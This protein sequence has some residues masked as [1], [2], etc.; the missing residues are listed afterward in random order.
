MC[1]P[2]KAQGKKSA[3][4]RM[5]PSL[6]LDIDETGVTAKFQSQTFK[7]ARFRVG[8]KG[9]E[10][11]VGGAELDPLQ[12]RFRQ[13]VAD[14][15]SQL[16]LVDVGKDM[17][18]GRE[19]GNSTLSTGTPER[20]SGPRPEMIP[21]PETPTLSAQLPSPRATL[22]RRQHPESFFDKTSSPTHAP[23]ADR[24]QYDELT[25]GQLR[26]QRSQRGYMKKESKAFLKTH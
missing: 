14:L 8:A 13:F 23:R 10:Q 4:R 9:R 17:E 21:I 18:V 11:D 24:A 19:D 1:P 12:P 5:G 16:R 22:D 6:I 2:F 7:V 20:G 3:P 26:D 15:G 25:W